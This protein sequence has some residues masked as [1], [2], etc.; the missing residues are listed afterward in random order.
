MTAL[1][2]RGYGRGE[3]LGLARRPVP[4]PGP[5]EVRV[6]VEACGANASDWEFITGRPAYARIAR[7]FMR[8]RDVFGSDVVGVVD[9]LGEG[10]TGLRL[11][12][13]VMADTFETFGGFAEFCVTKADLWVPLP[14]GISTIHAAA[15]P[16]S[17]TIACAAFRQGV[18]PG[19]RVLVNG[20]GGGSGPLAIQMA[21]AAGAEVWAVDTAGKA[22][23][24][25]EAGAARV[26]DFARE[27]YADHRAAFDIVLD[28][29]GTRPMRR[30]RRTLRPGGRYMLVGGPLRR[31]IGAAL[32]SLW[33]GFTSRKVGLLV[34]KQGPEAL[35]ALA[36][37]VAD[38]TLSPV[39]GEVCS[40]AG[41]AEA[42]TL[43]GAR[44]VAG[45]L[46]ITP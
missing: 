40:L 22:D 36:R 31:V 4:D 18:K 44:K 37:M 1:V 32:A 38:G 35:P 7:S 9:R 45:K 2:C 46:V 3:N 23:V 15:L 28:L 34:V 16:Q 17:G 11:G 13:R 8:G 5:G 41:A 21:V 20:G 12:E 42:L 30:V 33:T 25:R 27:D 14:A 29:W 10:V 6:Q 19:M 43:M 24:M 26:L 39:V